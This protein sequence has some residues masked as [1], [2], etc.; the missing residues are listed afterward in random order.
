MEGQHNVC[1]SHTDSISPPFQSTINTPIDILV[2]ELLGSFGD[3]EL[4]PECLD[5]VT[6]LL[7]SVH[8]ISIP[9]SYS[10]HLSPISAPRLHAEISTQ[11]VS[12]PAAP[13]TPYV[14]MLHAVDFLSTTQPRL[15]MASASIKQ[16]GPSSSGGSSPSGRSSTNTPTPIIEPPTPIVRTA[17]SF[18]HPNKNIPAHSPS[19]P[20]ISNSHNV[21]QARLTFPCRERGVCHGLAGYFEAVLYEDIEL[22]TNP[23][24]MDAKSEGM[25]SWFPIY[26]PLKVRVYSP[27]HLT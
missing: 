14:V 4:S 12:N 22:S 27:T 16:P 9:A 21:R 23:V 24:T 25:I 11:M 2:S 3:N 5:G 7:N 13:E 17:W 8:G 15:N 1:S 18:S 20:V 19:L 26:F 6:H 10:A